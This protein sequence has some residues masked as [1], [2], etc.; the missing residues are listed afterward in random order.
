MLY[1]V[2]KFENIKTVYL[3]YMESGDNYLEADPMHSAIEIAKCNQSFYTTKSEKFLSKAAGES[4]DIML[5][6]FWSI[7]DIKDLEKQTMK[8]TSK[9]DDGQTV[10]WLCIKWFRFE[11]AEPNV[12]K[13]TQLKQPWVSQA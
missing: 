8:N 10:N 12:V 5:L 1:A 9:F 2:Q 4:L 3:K 6:Q 11:K 13:Y 7:Y